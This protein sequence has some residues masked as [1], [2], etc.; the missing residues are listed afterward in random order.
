M[1]KHKFQT[2]VNQLLHLIIHSLYSHREIFLR[3][4]ISNASDAL[5]KL[6]FL[7]L[8]D[9]SF[10]GIGFDPRIDIYF[11]GKDKKVLTISD[12][13]IGMNETDLEENLGTIAN[14]GTRNFI[15]NL[16]GEQRKDSGLIGQFGVGFYSSF[17]VADQVE[18]ISRK[19]GEEK[20]WKWTSDG[21]G[22]YEI[23]GDERAEQ[24]T[25]VTLHLN[26]DGKEYA[27]RW[28][29][30]SVVKKYSNHV[31]FPIF[32]HFDDTR[33]EGE[34]K[35]AKPVTEP[36]IEQI[37]AASALWK[38][39]KN[40]LTQ[41]DYNDFY[42]TIS[43]DNEDPLHCVHTHAEGTMDY[44]TL[45]YFPSINRWTCSGPIISPV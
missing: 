16:T 2:E 20:A 38:L 42:K 15:H 35:D 33:Y 24:G 28:E 25:T 17:M 37:N 5:D 36:K 9:E 26:E 6:K 31:P 1:T 29:I 14:S 40:E 23:S 41:E 8:T 45:F 12:N 18:V 32:L 22:E 44:T 43:H 3:E 27:S 21:K 7:T 4:L 39:P 11:D 10:K 19:V 34:G 30:E 13:G